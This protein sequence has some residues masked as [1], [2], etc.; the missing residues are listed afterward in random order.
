MTFGNAAKIKDRVLSDEALQKVEELGAKRAYNFYDLGG[1]LIYYGHNVFMDGRAD[2]YQGEV[3]NDYYS[4]TKS[5]NDYQKTKDII[6]KYQ[7]DAFL[8]IPDEPLNM[9]LEMTGD[10]EEY[11]KDDSIRIW[12][13]QKDVGQ[14]IHK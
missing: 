2:M 6:E 8:C 1:E 7:F 3:F 4:L 14:M 11:Y 9:Y 10:Y 5:L 12:I 13:P